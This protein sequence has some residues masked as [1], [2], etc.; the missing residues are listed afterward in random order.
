[1]IKKYDDNYIDISK[2]SA[3]T[4]IR[5]IPLDGNNWCVFE[6]YIDGKKIEF[7]DSDYQRLVSLR[8]RILKDW[9]EV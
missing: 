4:K 2:V 3:V 9:M 8:D 1:M 5:I 7:E 6:V